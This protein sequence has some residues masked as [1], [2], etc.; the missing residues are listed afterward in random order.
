MYKAI[1]KKYA[2]D[3]AEKFHELL[4]ALIEGLD[5]NPNQDFL[6]SLYMVLDMGNDANGQFFTPYSVCQLMSQIDMDVVTETV[7]KRG[8]T[9]VNDPACGAGA[10][11]IS[12]A[13]ACVEQGINYQS[14]ILFV[15]QDIDQ[16]A[17]CMCYLQLSL[18]GC[19]G[20]IIVGNTLTSPP[21]GGEARGL[22][23]AT[24][25]NIWFTPFYFRS[26][27]HSRRLAAV[28]DK[29]TTTAVKRAEKC[30]GA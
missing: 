23:P 12:F 8:W 21:A 11:L 7:D 2:P 9:S 10:T 30:H 16:T 6:G 17:A 19:P 26:E 4:M 14:S 13:N 25:E 3:E 24:T 20:Y 28:M 5:S 22:I 18:L 27:W 1:M 15:G 29:L